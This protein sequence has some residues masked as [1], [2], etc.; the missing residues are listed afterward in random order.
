MVLVRQ[1]PAEWLR[2]KL[3]PRLPGVKRP[4]QHS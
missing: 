1:N 3:I 4:E 2:H